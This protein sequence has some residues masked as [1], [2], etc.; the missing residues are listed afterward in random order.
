MYSLDFRKQV[1]QAL[2]KRSFRQV[3]KDFG[4]SLATIQNWK[5]ELNPKAQGER[6]SKISLDALRRD[7]EMY[8]DAYQYERAE[9]FNCK[10]SAICKR[11]K[12]IKVSKKNS[13]TSQSI[14]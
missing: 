3:A 2:E 12:K 13:E 14:S 10:Q 9:R 11:L 4:I 5:A 6:H 8:P 7:V 1:L